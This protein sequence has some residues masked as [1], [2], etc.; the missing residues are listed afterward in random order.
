MINGI[1]WDNKAPAFF[2]K[3]EIQLFINHEEAFFYKNNEFVLITTH[4]TKKPYKKITGQYAFSGVAIKPSDN[5]YIIHSLR[6]TLR[7]KKNIDNCLI[8]KNKIV[9]S[10]SSIFSNSKRK[11]SD[12]NHSYDKTGNSKTR[13]INYW[14]DNGD[15]ITLICTDWSNA[16]TNSYGWTDNLALE[17]KKKEY[18]NFLRDAYN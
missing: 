5:Q 9:K 18:N 16:I 11:D 10:I 17:I 3:E 7:F 1:F 4:H 8:E 12:K 15:L 13:A 6:G 2:T 14:F